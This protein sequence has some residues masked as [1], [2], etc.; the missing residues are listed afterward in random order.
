MFKHYV[1][2]FLLLL[3]TIGLFHGVGYSA[4][5]Y[6]GTIGGTETTQTDAY[7]IILVI[8]SFLIGLAGSKKKKTT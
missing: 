3:I 5:H 1:L 6:V 8:V 4:Y 7:V 2:P